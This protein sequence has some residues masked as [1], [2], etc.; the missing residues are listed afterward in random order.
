MKKKKSQDTT[1]VMA[2]A[3]QI[4]ERWKQK[5]EGSLSLQVSFS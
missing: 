4:K 3:Y 5:E 2:H 1:E